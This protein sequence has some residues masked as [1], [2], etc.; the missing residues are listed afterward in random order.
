MLRS[1]VTC[2]Y[3]AKRTIDP[4]RYSYVDIYMGALYIKSSYLTFFVGCRE[5]VREDLQRQFDVNAAVTAI[6]FFEF[7]RLPAGQSNVL[8]R[9]MADLSYAYIVTRIIEKAKRALPPTVA[10]LV[11]R[12]VVDEAKVAWT[13]GVRLWRNWSVTSWLRSRCRRARARGCGICGGRYRYWLG[14]CWDR[15][16]H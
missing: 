9:R 16:R 3:Q 2:V 13:V 11:G 8:C 15:P 12:R 5:P 6:S 7:E 14:E 10:G 4:L 1:Y